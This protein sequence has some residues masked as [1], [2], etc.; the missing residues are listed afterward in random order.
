MVRTCRKELKCDQ[1]G[2]CGGHSRWRRSKTWRS[3]SSSQIYQKYIYM[4]NNS[5]RTPTERWQRTSD[6]PK[7]KKLPHTP[8]HVADR[9]LVLQPGVRPEPLRWESWVQYIGPPDTSL[10]H[11]TSIG[12]S[13]PR[14]LCL[15]AKTQLRSTNSKPQC[16]TT[17]CQTTSKTGTQAHPLA[18]RLPKII[19]RSQTP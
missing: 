19:I 10:L 5:F 4:W 14:D 12:E 17:L 1:K 2:N 3:P 18:E 6:L 15:N 9:V 7:G 11:V 13:S 8:S 16:W